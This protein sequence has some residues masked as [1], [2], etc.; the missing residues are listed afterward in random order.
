MKYQNLFLGKIAETI[1]KKCQNLFSG[2]NKKNISIFLSAE[3]C[4][5]S[6]KHG[7]K[8]RIISG[9]FISFYSYERIEAGNV[10][11]SLLSIKLRSLMFLTL[12]LLNLDIPS[13]CKQCR[14]R[15]VGF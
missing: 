12:V 9:M 14:P 10:F 6:T 3:N 13:I 11:Y 1:C 2:K 8:L 7:D 15:S 5:Q 4:T